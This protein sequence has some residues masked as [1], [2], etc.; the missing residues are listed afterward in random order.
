[1]GKAE[2]YVEKYL[3][4]QIEALGGICWK[5]S[6]VRGVPDRVIVV[7]GHTVFVETKSKDGRLSPL[8]KVQIRRIRKQR[9]DAR[10][11]H[12]RELIDAFIIEV[13]EPAP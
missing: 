12:T 13:K 11:M 6:S 8:Q 7:N 2:G 1:M 3:R 10:V 4:S 5:F 9:G